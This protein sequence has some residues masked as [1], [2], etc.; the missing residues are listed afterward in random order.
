[1]NKQSHLHGTVLALA[2]RRIDAPDAQ[3][4][5]FP[6]KNVQKVRVRLRSLFQTQQTAT[7]ICSAA[8]GSDLLALDVAGELDI[9]RYI[10]LPYDVP[11]FRAD[12]VADRPG[13]WGLLFD[14]ICAEV[15]DGCSGHLLVLNSTEENQAGWDSANSSI[16]D[17]AIELS[18]SVTASMTEPDLSAVGV[19]VWD[20]VPWGA[21][22]VTSRFARLV[23]QRG[24]RLVEVSTL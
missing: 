6:A 13:D 3:A 7:L 1:M 4:S 22:D 16:I 24:L 21:A 5:R 14:R 20:G 12:S 19:V 2:G 11:R 9:E 18:Q 17:K 8:C 15:A 23:K 10:I